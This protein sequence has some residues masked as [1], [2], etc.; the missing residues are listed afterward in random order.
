VVFSKAGVFWS[1]RSKVLALGILLAV[2]SRSFGQEL[3]WES[4][5]VRYGFYPYGAVDDFYQ[6]DVCASWTLP[7]GWD[8][9]PA[10][11]LQMRLDGS[12]GLLGEGRLDAGIFSFGSSVC[13][14]RQ[15]SPWSFDIGLSPTLIT[16]TEFSSKDIGSP[17]QFTSHLAF[18]FDLGAH[19]RLSYRFQHMSNA[20][21]AKPN[22]GLNM[23][24]LGVSYL[25]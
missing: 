14:R 18:N 7:W 24:M 4:V 1:G 15:N 3:R 12:A 8:L 25:F 5:G 6:A 11:R 2:G 20:G 10:W 19:V 17:F 22:P 16:R 9:D 21:I 13:L 23:H